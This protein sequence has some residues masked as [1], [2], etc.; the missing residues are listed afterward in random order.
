ML[1][2]RA[3]LLAMHVSIAEIS[4][5][6]RRHHLTK[7]LAKARKLAALKSFSTDPDTLAKMARRIRDHR[8]AC[9]CQMC[10]NPRRSTLSKGWEKL[11][12]QERRFDKN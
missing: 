5:A 8:T 11:T 2:S 4:R 12:I 9:S 7:A 10:R 3:R 1:D 6:V